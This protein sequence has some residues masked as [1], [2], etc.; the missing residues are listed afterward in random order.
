MQNHEQGNIILQ[1][2]HAWRFNPVRG[3]ER[4]AADSQ[5]H[6]SPAVL[7]VVALMVE[8]WP[9]YREVSGSSP[10]YGQQHHNQESGWHNDSKDSNTIRA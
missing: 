1:H 5:K 10:D 2:Q 6:E 4:M 8:P 9:P 3:S 7:V